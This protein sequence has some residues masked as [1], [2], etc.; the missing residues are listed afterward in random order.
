MRVV[1]PAP[2]A[3]VGILHLTRSRSQSLE[4]TALY[5]LYTLYIYKLLSRP[6]ALCSCGLPRVF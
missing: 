5:T 3:L 6:P 2:F 1:V 4:V